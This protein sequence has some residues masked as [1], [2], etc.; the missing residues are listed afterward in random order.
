MDGLEPFDGGSVVHKTPRRPG[1]L[2]G[3][4]LV[5]TDGTPLDATDKVI[6]RP[7]TPRVPMTEAAIFAH[8]LDP[9]PQALAQLCSTSDHGAALLTKTKTIR[10]DTPHPLLFR[11]Y[12]L[13]HRHT[14]LQR[15][16]T[17]EP[18][19]TLDALFFVTGRDLTGDYAT[20]AFKNNT[21]VL[22][23]SFTPEADVG[24][25]PWGSWHMDPTM[26]DDESSKFIFSQMSKRPQASGSN[27]PVGTENSVFVRGYRVRERR[28]VA[29]PPSP[30]SDEAARSPGDGPDNAPSDNARQIDVRAVVIDERAQ[31]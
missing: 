5:K 10:E 12:I 3:D 13:Q 27:K 29:N 17:V 1:P 23:I 26:S 16:L 7:L 15:A 20:L 28:I 8:I 11:E 21:E 9:E 19:V 4:K 24:S 31:F 2:H 25:G 30:S 18:T 14:L 6:I 22:D